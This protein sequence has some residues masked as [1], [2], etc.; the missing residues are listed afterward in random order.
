MAAAEDVDPPLI[1]NRTK[2]KAKAEELSNLNFGSELLSIVDIPEDVI[3]IA[4]GLFGDSFG[5]GE[6]QAW[7]RKSAE[8][9]TKC[10]NNTRGLNLNLC[11]FS[12]DEKTVAGQHYIDFSKGSTVEE[13]REE[14]VHSQWIP[15][16]YDTVSVWEIAED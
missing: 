4:G 9:L 2:A 16:C 12:Y 3:E 10:A 13:C 15:V 8:K 7:L 5:L 6:A 14:D 1:L 11:R